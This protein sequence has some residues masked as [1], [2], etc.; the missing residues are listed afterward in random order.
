MARRVKGLT[1]FTTQ[2]AQNAAL[3]QAGYDFVEATTV[4][5]DTYVAITA[6][7]GCT[8]TAVSIDTSVWDSLSSVEIPVGTTIFGRWSSVTI[9]TSDKAIVYRG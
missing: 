9:G 3:G 8:V 6:L 5:S 2:E 4:N 1:T 7:V